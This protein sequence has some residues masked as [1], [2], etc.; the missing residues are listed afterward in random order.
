[1]KRADTSDQAVFQLTPF[2]MS[3]MLVPSAGQPRIPEM[4]LVCGPNSRHTGKISV[5]AAAKHRS[6][7]G[8]PAKQRGVLIIIL[9]SPWAETMSLSDAQSLLL[10]SNKVNWQSH[11]ITALSASRVLTGRE[12]LSPHNLETK[13]L[14]VR[15]HWVFCFSLLQYSLSSKKW[16]W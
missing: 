11:P 14:W 8:A 13:R 4:H 9:D 2:R 6:P 12:R 5:W 10:V 1:M 16:T 15:G 3:R 7:P